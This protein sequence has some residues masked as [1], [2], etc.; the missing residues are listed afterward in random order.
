MT[1]HVN[2]AAPSLRHRNPPFD[3]DA[4]TR[5]WSPSVSKSAATSRFESAGAATRLHEKV[6]VPDPRQR[7]IAARVSTTL[8]R[9]GC[10][11]PLRSAMTT[12]L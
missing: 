11:S 10:V 6:P 1:S 9:S 7:S 3:G 8:S 4:R 2:T 5:S 12:P